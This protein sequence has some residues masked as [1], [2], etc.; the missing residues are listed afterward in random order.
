MSP[1]SYL[2][3]GCGYFGSG[4]GEK[5]QRKDL[6]SKVTVVDKNEEAIKKISHL[7]AKA[8]NGNSILPIWWYQ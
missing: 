2:V 3:I 8:V 1:G 6:H 7:P 5:I 4:A